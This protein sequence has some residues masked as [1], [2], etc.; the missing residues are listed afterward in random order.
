M[1]T[2]TNL[3]APS[4]AEL[5]AARAAFTNPGCGCYV[6]RMRDPFDAAL[7]GHWNTYHRSSLALLR[8][9][10]VNWLAAGHPRS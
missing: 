10:Q 8:N 4:A 6:Q 3:V 9:D 7:I 2:S 1:S 5:A